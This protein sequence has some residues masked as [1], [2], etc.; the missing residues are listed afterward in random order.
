MQVINYNV[1]FVDRNKDRNEEIIIKTVDRILEDW[2]IEANGLDKDK[3][4]QCFLFLDEKSKMIYQNLEGHN[5]PEVN[6]D[7]YTDIC[8]L[9]QN[10]LYEDVGFDTG[11]SISI[12]V[13]EVK[14]RV[15]EICLTLLTVE[16][17][18]LPKLSVFAVNMLVLL[19]KNAKY[20]P[21]DIN[22][23]VLK[24]IAKNTINALPKK[25]KITLNEIESFYDKEYT[26]PISAKK[27]IY[28]CAK[29]VRCQL[30]EKLRKDKINKALENLLAIKAIQCSNPEDDNPQYNIT[31]FIY[32]IC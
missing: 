8:L 12:N 6:I 4:L 32:K 20:V 26:C 14:A 18:S 29:D 16:G 28:F 2:N 1:K 24:V 5:N 9:P 3:I 22:R 23:C 13:N 15:A 11:L 25:E 31:P 17:L 21:N 10:V 30:S 27:C 7:L 19:I